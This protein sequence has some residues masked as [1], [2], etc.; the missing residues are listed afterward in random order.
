MVHAIQAIGLWVGITVFLSALSS[1]L[2]SDTSFDASKYRKIKSAWKEV[3][4]QET[5]VVERSRSRGD[6]DGD[7]AAVAD[8]GGGDDDAPARNDGGSK[9]PPSREAAAARP[10]IFGLD[11]LPA[12]TAGAS[13]HV[14]LILADDMG[15]NDIGYRST[16]LGAATPALDELATAGVVLESYYT[17][18]SCTPAR[19]AL[20]TGRDA[21]GVGMGFDGPGTYV[22]DS[23]YGLP[24]DYAT[25]GDAFSSSGY[26][27]HMVGKWNLGHYAEAYLP[28]K[29]GF[30]SFVGYLGDQETYFTHEAYGTD[31]T[32]GTTYCDLMR[33]SSEDGVAAGE[34]YVDEYSTDLYAR[35]LIDVVR[36]HAAAKSTDSLFLYFAAQAPHAPLEEP[37]P[38]NLTAP[39]ESMLAAL[40]RS[41]ERKTFAKMVVN[42][43]N[44]VRKV[45]DALGADRLLQDTVVFFASDN[46]ACPRDGGSNWPLR[47]TKFSQFEGGVRVPAFLWSSDLAAAN[48]GTSFSPLVHVSDVFPTLLTA[49]GATSATFAGSGVDQYAAAAG[50]AAAGADDPR[51]EVLVHL[52]K[53]TSGATAT[54]IAAF[55]S[56]TAALRWRDWK[57]VL[58][59]GPMSVVA[60]DAN[61]S[62]CS[63]SLT[64]RSG[65]ASL[66]DLSTDA[67]ETVD[68]KASHP[69]VYAQMVAKLHGY[70]DA[71]PA[72]AWKPEARDSAYANWRHADNF[73]VPWETNATA[74]S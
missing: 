52:N 38:M 19:A 32:N 12:S 25:M 58:N 27:T 28:H 55:S 39:Q 42:L 62:D 44:N 4:M 73:I 36:E 71:A 17:L 16:D 74:S 50:T 1:L 26:A 9:V 51:D 40:H 23:A 57:L 46:G 68:A 48:G 33:A 8:G 21:A 66:F 15:Y 54:G 31:P 56:T 61:A 43:D 30:D 64:L 53:W 63:C 13:K 18:P 10:S 24:L 45:V 5:D 72:S 6:D 20:F 65:S 35:R 34:C 60:P 70:F 22:I 37:P 2:N 49:A 41:P 3:S 47:G 59:E 11:S 69:E 14:L 7:D 67:N 29:R